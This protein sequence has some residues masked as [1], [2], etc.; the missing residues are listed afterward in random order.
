LP[1]A[2]SAEEPLAK[3]CAKALAADPARKA[4][5][6]SEGLLENS[7]LYFRMSGFRMRLN[8]GKVSGAWP[9]PNLKET[10]L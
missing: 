1:Q 3:P 6:F 7:A 4:R 5:A 10:A 2:G 8:F 9:D